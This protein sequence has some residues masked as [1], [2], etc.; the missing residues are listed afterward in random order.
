MFLVKKM[1]LKLQSLRGL[2]GDLNFSFLSGYCF[3]LRN[4]F[5]FIFLKIGRPFA[6]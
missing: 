6:R 5:L 2:A 4:T 1:N 3:N